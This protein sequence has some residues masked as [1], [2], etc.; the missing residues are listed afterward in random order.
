MV[1]EYKYL[2]IKEGHILTGFNSLDE[3]NNYAKKY[4][5]HV[6]PN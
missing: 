2:V 5:A 4:K 1:K 3:A 6:R